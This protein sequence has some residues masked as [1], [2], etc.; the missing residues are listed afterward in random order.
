MLQKTDQPRDYSVHDIAIMFYK[1]LKL[2]DPATSTS[3]VVI[4]LHEL[5]ENKTVN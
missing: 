3:R 5:S 1:M 2:L 4:I